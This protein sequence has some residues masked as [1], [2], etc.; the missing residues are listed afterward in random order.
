MALKA[1]RTSDTRNSES[2]YLGGQYAEILDFLCS[3]VTGL[4]NV[5]VLISEQG[6]GKTV[7]LR[8][9][10]ERIK[11]EARTA[12][13]FWTLFKPKDFVKHLLFEMGSS[14][15]PPLDV[16]AAQGQ[17]ANLLRRAAADGKRFV[18]AI[19][20]AHNLSPATFKRLSALLDRDTAHPPQV[21]LLLAGLP[22]LRG[23]LADPEASGI[24]ERIEGVMTIA[25]LN[26]EQTA[27]YIGTRITA[28]G[29]GPV[30]QEQL[31][32]I[33]ASSGGVFRTIDKLC[34]QLLLQNESWQQAANDALRVDTPVNEMSIIT[35]APVAR[36]AAWATDG[37]G[38]WSGTMAE[39]AAAT[40]IS[41]KEISDAVENRTQE[42]RRSGIA[43]AV[44]RSPG[45]PRMIT[46]SQV[47]RE[48]AP[49][50]HGAIPE[51]HQ[52]DANPQPKHE[53]Q[54]PEIEAGFNQEPAS[55]TRLH[56][57]KAV[58]EPRS[59][60]R[61]AGWA[62]RVAL[63]LVV[64]MG[65]AGGLLYLNSPS[66]SYQASSISQ[67]VSE[68]KRSSVADEGTG[69]RK[70][71]ETGA[72]G[73][74][75]AL[76]DR[77]REGKGVLQD[78]KAGMTLYEQAAAKGDSVAQHRLGLALSSGSG[79]VA[80]DRV[81]A[82]AWLVMARNGGQVIDKATLDSLTHSLTPSE[83]LD[84]RY[85]LGLMYEHGIGCVPDLV[86]ADEWFLLGAAVG[87]GRSRAE[88]TGVE[89]RMSPGQI[90]QAHARS[91]D[92]LRRH[93]IKAASNAAA[94]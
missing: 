59:A 19:D 41:V 24:R 66:S 13:V 1:A 31:A 54:E 93:T 55:E 75:T 88:S 4:A 26:A 35:E 42:L 25:P 74:Q 56:S 91:D 27:E 38:I 40:G 79:G 78:D 67:R 17:F 8:S 33:A 86:L 46:L 49:E 71:A 28:L 62:L 69:L 48:Q 9:A 80:A 16:K 3:P 73:S 23:R 60:N 18:L 10:I 77:D 6:L 22:G 87:D 14:E 58:G 72:I 11:G 44:Q 37:P 5:K 29:V 61:R 32:N 84:V 21:T 92:W 57:T 43:S 20:E 52:E 94:R 34:H 12:F 82:Y 70:R 53:G 50:P 76:P 30:A 85:R 36:I 45:K 64:I 81:A 39:L 65:V 2:L 83:I 15:R 7:L 90:S 89:R 63:V 68:P 47:E 51:L